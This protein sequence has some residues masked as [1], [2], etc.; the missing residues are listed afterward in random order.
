[1]KQ[2]KADSRV[3]LFGKLRFSGIFRFLMQAARICVN[4][5]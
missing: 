5:L 2:E 3:A 1:M 4:V